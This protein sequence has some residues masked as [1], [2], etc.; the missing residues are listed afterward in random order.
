MADLMKR[1][2]GARMSGVLTPKWV[3]GNDGTQGS[4]TR[5]GGT[6][7]RKLRS[8]KDDECKV[9]Q[10]FERVVSRMRNDMSAV[11]WRIE[12]SRDG[13]PEALKK[14]LKNS[15]EAMVGAVEKAMYGVSDGIVKEWKERRRR[16]RLRRL[17]VTRRI[18]REKKGTGRRQR[19]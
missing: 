8:W 19:D 3:D 11:L 13:S 12:R 10:V 9:E 6:M 4:Q 2:S 1:M 7:A 15:L 5:L 18:W 17:E 16:R 14:L